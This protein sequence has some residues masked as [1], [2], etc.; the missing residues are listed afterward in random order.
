MKCKIIIFEGG[1]FTGKST[2]IELLADRLNAE[3]FKVGIISEGVSGSKNIKNARRL[4]ASY[5]DP[6]TDEIWLN[7]IEHADK[8]GSFF[9]NNY[10]LKNEGER[11]GLIPYMFREKQIDMIDH[12]TSLN[13]VLLID[14]FHISTYVYSC[15]LRENPLSEKV[16]DALEKYVFSKLKIVDVTSV[17]LHISYEETVKRRKQRIDLHLDDENDEMLKRFLSV[18]DDIKTGKKTFFDIPTHCVNTEGTVSETH[19][20][21]YEIFKRGR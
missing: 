8:I 16:Y 3:G 1:D 6:G 11:L 17:L 15:R 9:K 12:L 7:L 2:Q 4:T 13:D 20:R 5:G 10:E 19:D 21:I 18:V 14:R